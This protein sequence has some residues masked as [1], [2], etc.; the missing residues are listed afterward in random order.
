MGIPALLLF[1]WLLYRTYRLGV[2]VYRSEGDAF[3]RAMG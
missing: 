2:R 3:G 1:L